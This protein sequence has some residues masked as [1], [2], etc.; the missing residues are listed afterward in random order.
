MLVEQS[1]HSEPHLFAGNKHGNTTH[2][3][4]HSQ[5]TSAPSPPSPRV[6]TRRS[7]STCQAGGRASTLC[8]DTAG[9]LEVLFSSVKDPSRILFVLE[10]LPTST[11]RIPLLASF[12]NHLLAKRQSSAPKI[13]PVLKAKNMRPAKGHYSCGSC[14]RGPLYLGLIPGWLPLK[15]KVHGSLG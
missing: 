15:S 11:F 4:C 2:S 13:E 8:W 7:P 3:D 9:R 6:C 10:C 1:R 12:L 5:L 14:P